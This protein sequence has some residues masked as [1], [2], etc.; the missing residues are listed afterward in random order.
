MEVDEV[1]LGVILQNFDQGPCDQVANSRRPFVS[2]ACVQMMMASSVEARKRQAGRPS[3]REAQTSTR[4]CVVSGLMR[5]FVQ[6]SCSHTGAPSLLRSTAPD[7]HIE[8]QERP[9]DV[10][11]LCAQLRARIGTEV[12]SE[13]DDGV[14]Q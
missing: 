13:F 10:K 6:V 14:W 2:D 5:G 7:H 9:C 8:T 11:L 4:R 1:D 3:P 12:Q